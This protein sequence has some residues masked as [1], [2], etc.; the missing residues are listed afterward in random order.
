MDFSTILNVFLTATVIYLYI[1]NKVNTLNISILRIE[2]M[3]YCNKLNE[4]TR[5]F[6][7]DIREIE[8]KVEQ[9]EKRL[10]NDNKE[11]EE[12]DDDVE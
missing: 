4:K 6:T 9:L 3:N 8:K 2:S 11:E 1:M 7:I 5:Q 10:K 12:D